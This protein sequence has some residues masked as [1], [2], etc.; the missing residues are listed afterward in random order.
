MK[1]GVSGCCCAAL[2]AAL[3]A[4]VAGCNSPTGIAIQLVGKAVDAVETQK[5]G[6]E[7]VG[8]APVAADQ[9]LGQ[10]VDTWQQVQGPTEWRVYSV[11]LDPLGKQR[12]VVQTSR[13]AIVSVA[14]VRSE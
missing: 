5:L 2:G 4:V 11:P 13:G 8:K 14:K 1:T 9:K 3:T 12:Y 6:E 7:L 10:T